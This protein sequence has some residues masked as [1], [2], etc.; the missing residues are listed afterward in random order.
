[1][2]QLFP[3]HLWREGANP[4]AE[5]ENFV[6]NIISEVDMGE[7]KALPV[8]VKAKMVAKAMASI[9]EAIEGQSQDECFTYENSGKNIMMHGCKISYREGYLSADLSGDARLNELKASAKA[10]EDLLKQAFKNEGKAYI[11]DPE[12]G[13]VVPVCPPKKT[14]STI[15][16][17][18]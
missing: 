15:A 16:V 2:V 12:T 7:V 18:L 13:E 1:M 10:R 9:I 5:L 4:K 8:Y 17:T 14:K 3:E 6:K 11:V